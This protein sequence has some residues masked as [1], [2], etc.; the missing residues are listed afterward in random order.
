MWLRLSKLVNFYSILPLLSAFGLNM[1]IYSGTMILCADWKHYD[2]TLPIDW[3]V[4]VIPWF[5]YIYFGC[6]LF[7]IINYIMIGHLGKEHFYRFITADMLSRIVC[8]LF[9]IL[10]PTTN[11]ELRESVIIDGSS[12]SEKMMQFLYMVDQPTN[13]FPSIHCLVSWYC[14]V[15]IRKQ[16]AIPLWYRIFSCLF[17]IAVCVSTQVTKQHYIVD[18]FA[19]ILL[20]EVLYYITT[21]T[22]LYKPIM[23]FFERMNSKLSQLFLK[24]KNFGE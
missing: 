9:F 24:E 2:L 6:Y 1:L 5:M 14:Y 4:P 17:A 10:L 13:L 16:K 8:G 20:A 15:G 12:F 23:S 18:I 3:H 22:N 19:G 21:H 11:L 7:W